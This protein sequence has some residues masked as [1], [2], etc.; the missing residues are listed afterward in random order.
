MTESTDDPDPRNA[1]LWVCSIANAQNF[2]D[3]GGTIEDSPFAKALSSD[4]LKGV[5]LMLDKDVENGPLS[6][7]WVAALML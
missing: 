3:I 4:L 7:A 2:V 1:R 6:R 5:T